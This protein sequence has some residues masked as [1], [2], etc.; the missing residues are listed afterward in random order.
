MFGC[1]LFRLRVPLN[2]ILAFS[3]TRPEAGFSAS[4]NGSY[5]KYQIWE[6][7]NLPNN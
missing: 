4:K 6:T 7:P 5:L 2:P 1:M 3:I